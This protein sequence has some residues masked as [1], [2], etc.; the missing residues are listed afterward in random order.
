MVERCVFQQG[1]IAL[2]EAWIAESV[3]FFIALLA[4]LW[5]G[6]IRPAVGELPPRCI[7]GKHP[8]MQ[9]GLTASR[10]LIAYYVWIIVVVPVRVIIAASC[11]DTDVLSGTVRNR[12]KRLS[13]VYGEWNA[14][15]QDS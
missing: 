1:N 10:S 12:L 3:I 15:L 8:R 11:R 14:A 2:C 13:I 7:F 5:Q 6:K 9:I 4:E